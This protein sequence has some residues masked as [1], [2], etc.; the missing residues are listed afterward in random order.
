MAV[1][2]S[3]TRSFPVLLFENY[4]R[5]VVLVLGGTAAVPCV[6]GLPGEAGEPNQAEAASKTGTY[7]IEYHQRKADRL[8]ADW[9]TMRSTYEVRVKS[10]KKG[11][12]LGLGTGGW[13]KIK[14]GTHK[15]WASV[16]H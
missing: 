10:V 2:S 15:K 7:K 13:M 5:W 12:R 9:G 16:R 1:S 4:K 3:C 11:C 14:K 8:T 6:P